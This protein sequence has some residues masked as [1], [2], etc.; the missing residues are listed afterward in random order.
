MTVMIEVVAFRLFRVEDL[1]WERSAWDSED[2]AVQEIAR[3]L[4]RVQRGRGDDQLQLAPAQQQLLEQPKQHVRVDRA[5][6][7]LI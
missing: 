1:N 7:R 3:E 6:V 5:L 4:L 2:G